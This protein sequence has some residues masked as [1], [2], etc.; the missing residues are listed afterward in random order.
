MAPSASAPAPTTGTAIC[1]YCASSQELVMKGAHVVSGR[2]I[3]SHT[4]LLRFRDESGDQQV[5]HVTGKLAAN[6]DEDEADEAILHSIPAMRTIQVDGLEVR[7]P[8]GFRPAFR[9]LCPTIGHMVTLY[10]DTEGGSV[11]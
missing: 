5:D 11:Q 3:R 10:G 1:P 7:I 4:E 8:A 9:H 2:I 6:L